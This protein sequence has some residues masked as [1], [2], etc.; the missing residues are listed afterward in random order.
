VIPGVRSWTRPAQVDAFRP[1]AFVSVGVDGSIVLWCPK[2]EMGQ[3]VLTA[4]P[5]ILAEELEAD[6]S[7]VSV[8][9]AEFDPAFGDQTTASSQSVRTSYQPL[10]QAGAVA[11]AMLRTAAAGRWGVSESECRTASSAV[12]HPPSGR[13]ATYAEVAAEA[14]ELPVPEK[15]PLKDEADFRLIG[16]PV[17]RVDTPSKVGG[18]AV[19]G[20]DVRVPGML[21][22]VL[23]RAP[24]PGARLQSIDDSAARAVQGVR[25]VVQLPSVA[26]PYPFGNMMGEEGHQN[27]LR[28]SVA[29]LADSTWA[30]IQGREALKVT[31]TDDPSGAIDTEQV[32]TRLRETV[33][34]SLETVR[35]DGD[36]DQALADAER[37]IEASYDLPF[38]AHVAMEPVNCT[39][40]ATEDGCRLWAPTQIPEAAAASAAKILGLDT[41]EVEVNVTYLGGGFGRRLCQDY[42]AQAAQVSRAAG[43]PVKVL[44]TREDDIRYD[45]FRQATHHRL[46]AALDGNGRPVAWHHRFATTA[47]STFFMGPD[48]S[49]AAADEVRAEDFPCHLIPNYRVEFG[50]ADVPV[51]VGWWRSVEQSFHTFVTE[52]FVD[53]LAAAAGRDPLQYRLDLIGEP[54]RVPWGR[55]EM[56]LGRLAH[57]LRAVAARAEWER[58]RPAG[59]A[60]GIA[61]R[62]AFGTYVAQVVEL[63]L[64][65]G[66]PRVHQLWC[67]VDPGRVI[68]PDTVTAQMQSAVAFGLTA[69]L[70]SAI[71]LRAGRTEQAN[72][73]SYGV[74][75]IDEAP[76]IDVH[77]VESDE[78][79]G[80]IGEPGVTPVAPAVANAV[81][82]LTGRRVRHIP[83]KESD[84]G[85][86]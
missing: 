63:S 7:Q 36:V 47:I 66:R 53:E 76:W 64:S 39:A 4:L 10:R 8:R 20:I 78:A 31:W 6:W 65:E 73:D 43:A 77:I 12:L 24:T 9:Q 58:P 26:I 68:N 38:E 79:P 80:G 71:T 37:V 44:W 5:M 21:Y 22:A 29:V 15:A 32:R 19:Y 34:G 81:F 56:N 17:P 49:W 67:V 61:G 14:A 28:A 42:A 3:G 70:K 13:R 84:L 2:S 33:D 16:T 62:F 86:T 18:T 35:D 74:L 55:G 59:R 54:R 69:A 72:F 60:L 57:V 52:S 30:A 82:A 23:E 11:R 41:E 45:Y 51:R 75:R 25:R 46:K 48:V 85:G 1:N 50:A 83:I 40:H 27:F